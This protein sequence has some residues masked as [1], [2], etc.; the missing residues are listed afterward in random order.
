V[1]GIQ[2]LLSNA[3][4]SAA[5]MCRVAASL[6]SKASKYSLYCTRTDIDWRSRSL[7]SVFD[8]LESLKCVTTKVIWK[9]KNLQ[10]PC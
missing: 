4:S 7:R 6:F 10:W 5:G 9:P 1:T 2:D 8:I 3:A